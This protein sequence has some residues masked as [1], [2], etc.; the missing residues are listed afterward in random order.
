MYRAEPASRWWDRGGAFERRKGKA[1]VGGESEGEVRGTSA[2]GHATGG[3]LVERTARTYAKGDEGR[4]TQDQ[5]KTE[6][7]GDVCRS[8]L[9]V[10]LAAALWGSVI[11]HVHGLMHRFGGVPG[12]VV[13]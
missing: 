2:D 11:E 3:R 7:D 13:V 1:I 5:R 6:L 10:V 4:N 12:S 9:E 8:W